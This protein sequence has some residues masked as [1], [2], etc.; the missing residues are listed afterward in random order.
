MTVE[1]NAVTLLNGQTDNKAHWCASVYTANASGTEIA[2]PD[3][4]DGYALC[5]ERIDIMQQ[6][7]GT[8]EIEAPAGT[9]LFGSIP[10]NADG[11]GQVTLEFDP[12]VE[13][14]ASTA[15]SFTAT[16]GAIGVITQGFTRKTT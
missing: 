5:I 4:G 6:T 8:V 12:P 15:L 7:D 16:S 13:I 1:T 14:P 11:G 9:V 3:P 10:I 2:V